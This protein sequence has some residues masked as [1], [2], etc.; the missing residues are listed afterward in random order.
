[1]SA[2]SMFKKLMSILKQDMNEFLAIFQPV[3]G[4]LVDIDSNLLNT[5]DVNDKGA[6][7]VNFSPP[8]LPSNRSEV[9]YYMNKQL[10]ARYRLEVLS[11]GNAT[12]NITVFNANFG[13]DGAVPFNITIL[14][15]NPLV[16]TAAEFFKNSV[17]DGQFVGDTGSAFLNRL[18]QEAVSNGVPLTDV[19]SV[20]A[21]NVHLKV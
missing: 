18:A 11:N 1:M 12:R 4:G 6:L 20:T 3:F 19:F 13:D 7:Q 2:S 5:S 10:L 14:D 8:T 21:G 15:K 16:G 9:F 17:I